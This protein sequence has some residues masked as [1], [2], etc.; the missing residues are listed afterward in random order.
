MRAWSRRPVRLA[1][2]LYGRTHEC[3]A[4]SRS[5]QP[6]RSS[7][8]WWRPRQTHIRRRQLLG[9]KPPRRRREKPWSG[10]QGA[11]IGMV[12]G[13]F[14]SAVITSSGWLGSIGKQHIGCGTAVTGSGLA[15]TGLASPS[16][17]V[18]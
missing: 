16:Y 10:S 2:T 9:W 18:D 17:S 7:D 4:C 11:G 8:V 3:G 12:A 13:M 1:A 14:G 5:S 6:S 15:A